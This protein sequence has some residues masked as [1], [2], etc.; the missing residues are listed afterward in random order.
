MA[1]TSFF[2]VNVEGQT[3]HEI[4]MNRLTWSETQQWGIFD[5][6]LHIVSTPHQAIQK[7]SIEIN[8]YCGQCQQGP[9][10]SN[11]TPYYKV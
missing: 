1:E 6:N 11:R 8:C 9:L 10:I 2:T 5:T 3:I 4:V 7:H